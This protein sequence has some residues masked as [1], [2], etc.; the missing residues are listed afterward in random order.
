MF[1]FIGY[2]LAYSALVFTVYNYLSPVLVTIIVLYSVTGILIE[3]KEK[4][5]TKLALQVHI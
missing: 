5:T 3:K 2:T 1:H 4:E